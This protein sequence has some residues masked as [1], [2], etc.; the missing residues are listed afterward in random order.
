MEN[1]KEIEIS[2]LEEFKNAVDTLEIYIVT[3]EYKKCNSL[4]YVYSIVM[5]IFSNFNI[6]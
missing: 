3:P 1:L 4:Y 6:I 2:E 5:R